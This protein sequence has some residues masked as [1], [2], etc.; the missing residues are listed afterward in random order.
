MSRVVAPTLAKDAHDTGLCGAQAM[1]AH[2]QAIADCAAVSGEWAIVEWLRDRFGQR[3]HCTAAAFHRAAT[4]GH[5]RFLERLYEAGADRCRHLPDAATGCAPCK[6]DDVSWQRSTFHNDMPSPNGLYGRACLRR[7]AREGRLD[8]FRVLAAHGS[9]AL[10][11]TECLFGAVLN[12]HLA[13]CA[14][15]V[16]IGCKPLCNELVLAVRNGDV[17]CLRFLIEATDDAVLSE[18]SRQQWPY[19]D[20]AALAIARGHIAVYATLLDKGLTS[21]PWPVVTPLH[22]VDTED[23]E[24]EDHFASS[25]SSSSS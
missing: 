2:A 23:H 9:L 8:V 22:D 3:A 5:A 17:A 12:G 1:S 16:S 6:D 15:L 20:F 11:L 14:L 10:E 24:T 13:L 4:N 18:L 21:E 7:L 19:E 25:S